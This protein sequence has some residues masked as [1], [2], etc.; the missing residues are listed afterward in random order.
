M[1]RHDLHIE[2][3]GATSDDLRDTWTAVAE[4][5]TAANVAAIRA[6]P[7]LPQRLAHDLP[8]YENPRRAP[9]ADQAV[10][11]LPVVVKRGRATCIEIC[12]IDAAVRRLSG[13]PRARVGLIDVYSP[14]FQAPVPFTYHAIVICGDG[15]VEDPT[16]ALPGASPDPFWASAGHCCQACALEDGQKTPCHTCQGA[17]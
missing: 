8:R 2:F 1:S 15:R 16:A 3:D 11:T 12:A 9:A 10:A 17:T 4:G 14:R 13:D 6:D 7:T 5:L